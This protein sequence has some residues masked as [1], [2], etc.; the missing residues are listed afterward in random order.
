MSF[1]KFFMAEEFA[2]TSDTQSN[3]STVVRCAGD[4]EHTFKEL[5]SKSN[6]VLGNTMS[7]CKTLLVSTDLYF[8]WSWWWHLCTTFPPFNLISYIDNHSDIM[9]SIKY[10]VNFPPNAK[11]FFHLNEPVTKP[12]LRGSKAW[13]RGVKHIAL[14]L[15]TA[16]FVTSLFQTILFF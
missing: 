5:S 13:A 12:E 9:K 11:N 1:I 10:H 2:D 8:L 3:D 6:T 15:L 16:S 14:F 7:D 4:A